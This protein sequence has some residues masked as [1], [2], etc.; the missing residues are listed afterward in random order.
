[1]KIHTSDGK[2]LG[3]FIAWAAT[4]CV[5]LARQSWEWWR[6]F[7]S[8]PKIRREYRFEFRGSVSGRVGPISGRGPCRVHCRLLFRRPSFRLAIPLT[9]DAG[10]FDGLGQSLG[11]GL[12]LSDRN[13]TAEYLLEMGTPEHDPWSYEIRFRCNTPKLQ[14]VRVNVKLEVAGAAEGLS[15]PA[16]CVIDLVGKPGFP[17]ICDGDGRSREQAV[18]AYEGLQ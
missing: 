1:M 9:F 17:V 7:T 14:T 6:W 5:I 15:L 2:T 8:G 13:G 16:T 10:W 18:A 4:L 3:F 12:R 11:A